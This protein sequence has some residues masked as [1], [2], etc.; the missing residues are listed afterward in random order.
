MEMPQNILE[1]QMKAGRQEKEI[2]NRLE[3]KSERNNT[4]NYILSS[5]FLRGKN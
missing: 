5:V 2:Q 3:V 4:S 1:S